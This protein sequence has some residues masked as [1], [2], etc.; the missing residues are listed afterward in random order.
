MMAQIEENTKV[1]ELGQRSANGLE[2]PTQKVAPS[3]LSSAVNG[4]SSNG[5][6]SP[7]VEYASRTPAA[8]NDRSG[9]R[10]ALLQWAQKAAKKY[11]IVLPDL[12]V[13]KDERR[14]K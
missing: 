6:T 9:A 14:Q 12:I 11:V 4:R 2:S 7:S 13:L 5:A 8:R 1:L 10:K 3:C